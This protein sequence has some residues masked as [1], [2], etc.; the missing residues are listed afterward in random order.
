MN[1]LDRYLFIYLLTNG[2]AG[3][4]GIYELP[5]DLM[6]SESGID[7]RDLSGVM[8]LRL[9]PKVFYKEGWIIITNFVKHHLG[10]GP[11]FL[12][13]VS[14]EFQ[15]VPP[16]IQAIAIDYGYPL[17]RVSI[18]YAS[19]RTDK[20]RIDIPALSA[21]DAEPIIEVREDSEGREKPA[22][23]KEPFHRHYEEMCKWAEKRRGF[24]FVNRKKQFAALKKARVN[25][26][27]P[28]RLRERW[29]E[30][31]GEK[32]YGETGFDWTTVVSS[33]DKKS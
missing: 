11:L 10:D 17:D 1:A 29:Q 27:G 32:F 21:K 22:K 3:L 13:G 4:T 28:T 5:L 18:P 24:D 8:L 2:R 7:A 33:F 30:F 14:N 26:I 12:R 31:E 23:S 20:I 15:K 9:E 19:N 16:K 25:D 6:G